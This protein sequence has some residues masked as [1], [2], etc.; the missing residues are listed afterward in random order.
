MATLR[1]TESATHHAQA[2]GTVARIT[3]RQIAQSVVLPEPGT[4]STTNRLCSPS[5]SS[6]LMVTVSVR[7]S[8]ARF[9]DSLGATIRSSASHASSA[10]SVWL[11]VALS[12]M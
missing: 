12:V 11:R 6:T 1:Q 9:R 8:R 7:V 3:E 4:P 5:A 10:S 2:L